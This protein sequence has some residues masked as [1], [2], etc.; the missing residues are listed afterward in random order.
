MK[1]GRNRPPKGRTT[2]TGDCSRSGRNEGGPKSALGG[3]PS[4]R[5]STRFCTRRN[6]GGPRSALG[7]WVSCLASGWCYAPQWRRAEIGPRRD[8]Q[9]ARVGRQVPAAMEEDRD[10]PSEGG[11]GRHLG[12]TRCHGRNGGGPRSALGARGSLA[13]SG[14]WPSRNGE[15]PRSALG[16][17]AIGRPSMYRA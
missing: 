16:R 9:M 1:E 17:A 14:H 11:P 2:S 6:G 8:G 7:G 4:R 15:G 12:R 5:R 10:R 3:W 13:I